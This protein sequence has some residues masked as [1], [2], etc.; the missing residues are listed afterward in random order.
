MSLPGRSSPSASGMATGSCAGGKTPGLLVGLS[1]RGKSPNE[2]RHHI[3]SR[4]NEQQT[5]PNR[6]GQRLPQ[7]KLVNNP[8]GTTF[9]DEGI[10]L[11]VQVRYSS[12]TPVSFLQTS[13]YL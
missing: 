9:T 4:N 2:S 7:V 11:T 3:N 6:Y 12:A 13:L 5:H 8:A 1:R 10:L